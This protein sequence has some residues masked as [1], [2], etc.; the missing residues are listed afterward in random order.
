MTRFSWIISLGLVV[1]ACGGDDA[2]SLGKYSEECKVTTDCEEG[3]EC[4][5]GLC[6]VRCGTDSTQC[7]AI[8]SGSICLNDYCYIACTS[9]PS[10]PDGLEC[11][12]VAT[13]TGTCRPPQ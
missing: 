11:R 12:M 13:P 10:C 9:T 4:A 7:T 3:L 1:G 5:S 2:P 8:D 6:S